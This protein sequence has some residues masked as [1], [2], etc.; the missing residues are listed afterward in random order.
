M[1]REP[2][3]NEAFVASCNHQFCRPCVVDHFSKILR[4]QMQDANPKLET[5]VSGSQCP[6]ARYYPIMVY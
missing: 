2:V 4:N 5:V 6:I 3:G 1:C